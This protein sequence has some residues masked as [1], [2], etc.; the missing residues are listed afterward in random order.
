MLLRTIAFQ[1]LKDGRGKRILDLPKYA[2]LYPI[3]EQEHAYL[4]TYKAQ[5]TYTGF[6]AKDLVEPEGVPHPVVEIGLPQT[7]SNQDAEQYAIIDGKPHYNLCGMFCIAYAA[8]ASAASVI[9]AIRAAPRL[10]YLL[11]N[12]GTS[13]DELIAIANLFGLKTQKLQS[14]L[15]STELRRPL[16]SPGRLQTLLAAQTTGELVQRGVPNTVAHWVIIESVETKNRR[17]PFSDV[18][19]YN[20]FGNSYESYYWSLVEKSIGLSI[21]GILTG[22]IR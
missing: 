15:W 10:R 7:L 12:S 3:E 14:A 2:V 16:I 20:P 4:V 9:D 13:E 1:P 17:L 11:N 21:A 19:V 6:V 5:K 22:E 18:V 8:N